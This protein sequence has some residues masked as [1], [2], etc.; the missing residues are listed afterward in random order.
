[1]ARRHVGKGKPEYRR[2]LPPEK[3]PKRSAGFLV[4]SY[5]EGKSI[6]DN[7]EWLVH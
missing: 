7:T 5:A 2:L 4:E 1:M 6:D 3:H